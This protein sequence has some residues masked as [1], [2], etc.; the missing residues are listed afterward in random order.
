MISRGNTTTNGRVLKVTIVSI[1]NKIIF[2]KVSVLCNS[3]V[4]MNGIHSNYYAISSLAFLEFGF[5]I[6]VGRTNRFYS[7]CSRRRD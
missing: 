4:G 1:L 3:S 6:E 2:L 5:P 7:F